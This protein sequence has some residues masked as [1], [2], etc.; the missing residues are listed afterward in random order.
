MNEEFSE[1]EKC[2][3]PINYGNAYVTIERNIE[4]AEFDLISYQEEIQIIDSVEVIT[5]CG[6]CGN[7][8]DTDMLKRLI[9]S[10]PFSNNRPSDN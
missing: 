6:K 1:C 7:A 10:I 2:G 8:F 4:Q 5:L 9:K 3:K